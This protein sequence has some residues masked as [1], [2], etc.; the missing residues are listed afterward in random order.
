MAS[1][2]PGSS[3]GGAPTRNYPEIPDVWDGVIWTCYE[4]PT[5]RVVEFENGLCPVCGSPGEFTDEEVLR[6]AGVLDDE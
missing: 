4:C 1:K 6:R 2:N 3:G 5:S